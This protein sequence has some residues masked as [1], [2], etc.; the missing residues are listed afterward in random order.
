MSISTIALIGFGEVGQALAAELS[1]NDSLKVKVYDLKLFDNRSVCAHAAAKA[2]IMR[3]R[4]ASEAAK[5]A[6]LIISAVTAAQT[7]VAAKS[8]VLGLEAG[9]WFLDLNSA[10]PEAKIAAAGVIEAATG[11]YVEASVMSPIEPK[12][13]ASPV[14][15]GGPHAEMFA[16]LI[17][18]LGFTDAIYYSDRLGKTAAAKLCRSVMIK[19]LEALISESLLAARHYGVEDT[20]LASL[21]NLFPHPD[22]EGY[23][24]Y[25]IS[26]TLEHGARRS[27]EMREAAKTVA[28]AGI[29]PWMSDAI[30]DLQAWAPDYDSALKAEGLKPMLD[31][32]RAQLK[33]E[34][35]K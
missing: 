16:S 21:N 27:E 20:V 29:T 2:D 17:G 22:W 3:C 32:M 19:G 7:V 11:R 1:V 13:L 6:D 4:S 26:R 18:G 10:S 28:E 5:G 33:S 31:A 24:R 23:A 35:T 15:L 8:V 34:E 12:R 14:L 25:M 30:A 9:A